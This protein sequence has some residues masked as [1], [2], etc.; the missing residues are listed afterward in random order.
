M[1]AA[2]V[3]LYND[4]VESADYW[5]QYIR[6]ELSEV[7]SDIRSDAKQEARVLLEDLK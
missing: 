4:I 7:A 5:K 1:K 6:S 2:S 3:G